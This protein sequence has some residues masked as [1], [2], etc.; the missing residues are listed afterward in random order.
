MNCLR[1]SLRSLTWLCAGGVFL[2]ACGGGSSGSSSL[3]TA[4]T[5]TPVGVLPK[6]LPSVAP[7]PG[8]SPVADAAAFVCPTSDSASA[9][10][11]GRNAAGEARHMLPRRGSPPTAVPGASQLVAVTYDAQTANTQKTTLAVRESALGATL[12]RSY[13]FSHANLVTHVLKVPT[14]KV[15]SVESSL[16][17]QAGVR[18]VGVTATRRYAMSVNAPYFPDDPYFTGFSTTVAPTVGAAVP[19]ATFEV[20]PLEENANVPGQWDMH[21]TRLEYAFAYSQ[22]GNGSGI[23]NPAALGSSS[24]KIA[25]I[26]TGQ[27]TTH[28]ELASKIVY[29]RCFI[30]N[31]NSVQSTSKFT[32]DEDGHG[33]DTAGIAGESTNNRLGFTAAGG[34]V[35]LY[36]YRVFP[37]PDDNCTNTSSTDPQCGTDTQD[38]ASAVEDAVSNHVNVISLSLGGTGCVNGA[39]SDPTEGAAIAD[40]I[41]ANIVVVAAAGNS[42]G[43]PVEAP[44]CDPGVIAVG[45]TGLA[46]GTTNGSGKAGG[47]AGAPFEYVASYSDYGSPGAAVGSPSAWGIVAPG[48]D[49]ANGNDTD[50][51][52]WV[53]NIW[54]STPF[55]ASA[56]DTSFE[57]SCSGDYPSESGTTDCRVLIA[58]TSMATPHVAGAAALIIS[59]NPSYQSPTLMK[60][61]LCS[62][63]ADISDPNEGCGRLDVYRAMA[64]ALGD[65][66]IPASSPV[67]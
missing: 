33:T 41:A 57:G 55:M 47:S 31:N 15:S 62:T 43:P 40:A 27:D 49:P 6:P 1:L 4:A 65:S 13:A 39:D 60:Q 53:E 56:S 17:L 54:T 9:A 64:T 20:G 10:A 38:I 29:Q 44:A 45:A 14:A 11:T 46:D 26:D 34:N 12:V 35:V 25:T 28:P 18:A 61:L 48:G 8:S 52:H 50:D 67:P 21:A 5:P 7:S 19:P 32:T 23:T 36:G 30:T 2:S 51:L 16:R 3:P 22:A 24:V 37:T 63:A 66:N 59:V 58:G 42:T